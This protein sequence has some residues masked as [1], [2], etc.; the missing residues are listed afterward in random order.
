MNLSAQEYGYL[1]NAGTDQGTLNVRGNYNYTDNDGN[2]FHISYIADENGFQPKGAHLPT[3]SALIKKILQYIAEHPEE[4][5][6]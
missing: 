1:N 3:M 2:T 6:E 5:G 4:N